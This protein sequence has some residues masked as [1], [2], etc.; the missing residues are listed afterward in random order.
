MLHLKKKKKKNFSS[1]ART[2]LT[3]FAQNINTLSLKLISANK[4]T[5][6]L[7][8]YIKNIAPPFCLLSILFLLIGNCPNKNLKEY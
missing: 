8:C 2:L 1:I 6:N 3:Y 7:K 4:H 5:K